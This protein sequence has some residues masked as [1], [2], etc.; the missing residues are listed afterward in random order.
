[1]KT[2]FPKKVAIAL[3]ILGAALVSSGCG[4]S[5]SGGAPAGGAAGAGGTAGVA[6]GVGGVGMP[7]GCVNPFLA[8]GVGG[9]V[10]TGAYFDSN[11]II[12]GTQTMDNNTIAPGQTFGQVIMTV[13]AVGAAYP[14]VDNRSPDGTVELNFTPMVSGV[15]G[16]TG[17]TSTFSSGYGSST[18]M[19]T[20]VALMSQAKQQL[21][22]SELQSQYPMTGVMSGIPGTMPIGTIGVTGTTSS[23]A[24]QI[25]VVSAAGNLSHSGYTLYGDGG[26]PNNPLPGTVELYFYIPSQMSMFPGVTAG[27][28]PGAMT[29][30]ALYSMNKIILHY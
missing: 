9:T 13:G 11:Y 25:C 24:T 20:F 21:V 7:A 2:I 29:G 26:S 8:T 23:L 30:A 5:N 12:W 10:Q 27:M 4:S 28:S 22:L 17:M 6:N 1:M 15:A 3:A 18:G 14:Y 16:V 19:L